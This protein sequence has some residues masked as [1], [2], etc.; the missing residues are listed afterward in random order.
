MFANMA[1]SL[2]DKERIVTTLVKAKEAR[3]VVERLVTYAKRGTIHHRR[4]AG[5]V[6]RDRAVLKKLFDELAP[7]YKGREGGYVRI[8]R[9]DERKGD[10]AL[11][12]ILE[13]VGRVGPEQ[14]K[15]KSKAEKAAVSAGKSAEV[16]ADASASEKPEAAEGKKA[17]TKASEAKE[18]KAKNPTTKPRAPRKNVSDETK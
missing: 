17:S 6:I 9:L 8:L 7:F 11:M 1:T 18:P 16:A 2:F 14:L 4:L 15:Q 5:R 12:A 10:N 3:G 13:L